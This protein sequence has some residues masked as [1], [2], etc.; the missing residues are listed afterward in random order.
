MTVHDFTLGS[1]FLASLENPQTKN[2]EYWADLKANHTPARVLK[3]VEDI[4]EELKDY[5][6]KRPQTCSFWVSTI[7]I[8]FN[9]STD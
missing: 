8:Q 9:N 7:F 3:Y 5:L 2:P 1:L 6:A 4:K